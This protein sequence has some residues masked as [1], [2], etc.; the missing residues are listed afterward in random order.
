[1]AIVV[2][3]FA[4]Y[5]STA[6][7]VGPPVVTVKA[8]SG[9]SLTGATLNG[10]VDQNGAA[11]T[12]KF[13]YGKTKLYGKSTPVTSVTGIG[14][15]P[16]SNLVVGLEPMTTYHF[17]VSATNSSGTTV[18]EDML[19]ETLLQ[20]YVNG[21][22][23]TAEGVYKAEGG[24]VT[25][26]GSSKAGTTKIVCN[27]TGSGSLNSSTTMTISGCV[28]Y[29]KGVENKECVLNGMPFNINLNGVLATS[30]ELHFTF[31]S[32]SCPIAATDIPQTG[33]VVATGPESVFLPVT[34]TEQTTAW[35]RP[36]TITNTATWHQ[37]GAYAGYTQVV[38]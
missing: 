30:Q 23:P 29:F 2:G 28:S 25:F 36:M 17:R 10:T 32:G 21:K 11:T 38:K 31:G 24:S 7:A 5:S 26:D 18:S 16:V 3:L 15:I 12:Y 4:V 19:F 33:F 20:W 22:P 14:A 27:E 37:T 35:G 6:L 34:L 1:M 9:F 13:E 8:A